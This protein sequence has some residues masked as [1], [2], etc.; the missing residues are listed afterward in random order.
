MERNLNLIKNDLGKHEKRILPRFPFCY[1]TFKI[2]EKNSKTFEVKDISHS[3]MQV[4]LKDGTH[5]YKEHES[6][7]G[8]IHWHAQSLFIGGKIVWKTNNRLGIEFEKSV[9]NEKN[10]TNF[11]SVK[12]IVSSFRPIHKSNIGLEIPAKLKF[13][14]RGDGPMEIFVWQHNDGELSKFQILLMENFVEWEDGFGLKTGRAVSKR[15]LDSPLL[16]EDE[17]VFIIDD[18][19]DQKRL[20]MAYEIIDCVPESYLTFEVIDFIKRKL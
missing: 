14:L 1:L 5:E 10:L 17:Y 2:D 15:N 16:T 13:W 19:V 12:N 7:K 4:A 11:L 6:L 8:S 9:E 3:G 18:K 20:K